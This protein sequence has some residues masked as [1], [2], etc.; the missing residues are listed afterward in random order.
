MLGKKTLDLVKKAMPAQLKSSHACLGNSMPA[1][2]LVAASSKIL[3][4]K[5]IR[6]RAV[7][8][9]GSNQ[10]MLDSMATYGLPP[11]N[12]SFQLGGGFTL[13]RFLKWVEEKKLVE[14]LLALK[15]YE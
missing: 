5:R 12:Q 1:V 15:E 14:G 11:D 8:H 7:C 13:D 3:A 10:E 6:L 9:G 4:G 2:Q